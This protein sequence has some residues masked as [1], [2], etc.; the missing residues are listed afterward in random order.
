MPHFI[1]SNIKDK[2][3]LKIL[4]KCVNNTFF[5][6]CNLKGKYVYTY[7][8]SLKKTKITETYII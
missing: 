6:S 3:H 7:I 8:F 2:T 1:N 5:I 4:K